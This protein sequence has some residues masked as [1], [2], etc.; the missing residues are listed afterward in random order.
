MADAVELNLEPGEQAI[1]D[2]ADLFS[3]GPVSIQGSTSFVVSL[4]VETDGEDVLGDVLFGNP[5]DLQSKVARCAG[6]FMRET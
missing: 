2:A 6:S 3:G 4:Q 5:S 1:L